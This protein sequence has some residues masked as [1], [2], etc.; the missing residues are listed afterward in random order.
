L[1]AAGGVD[2]LVGDV[3]LWVKEL[4]ELGDQGFVNEK[5]NVSFLVNVSVGGSPAELSIIRF[6]SV[7]LWL[8]INSKELVL[9]QLDKLLIDIACLSR[10]T[11]FGEWELLDLS[12]EIVDKH[13]ADIAQACAR[14]TPEFL[15]LLVIDLLE[16][17]RIT[18]KAGFIRCESWRSTDSP[19]TIGELVPVLGSHTV[20]LW[21]NGPEDWS[22]ILSFSLGRGS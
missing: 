9:I 10:K 22:D 16:P 14:L 12:G 20:A 2:G 17:L 7:N 19:T 3:F 18:N 6:S 11:S 5:L 13:L 8:R 21:F 15:L 4:N 1:G